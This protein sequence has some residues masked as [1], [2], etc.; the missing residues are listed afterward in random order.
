ML[1]VTSSWSCGIS[2]SMFVF[3]S[4]SGC[5]FACVSFSSLYFVGLPLFLYAACLLRFRRRPV[6]SWWIEHCCEDAIFAARPN[7]FLFEEF[8]SK[9]KETG[10]RET[11]KMGSQIVTFIELTTHTTLRVGLW[12]LSLSCRPYTKG[13]PH[14]SK[15]HNP[16]STPEPYPNCRCSLSTS[17]RDS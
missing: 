14:S 8:S 10:R 12:F 7:Q 15:T 16:L 11:G 17:G 5:M 3:V 2:M 13:N 4:L 1:H 6:K 9:Q